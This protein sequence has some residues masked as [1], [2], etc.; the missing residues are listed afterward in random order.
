MIPLPLAGVLIVASGLLAARLLARRFGRLRRIVWCVKISDRRIEGYGY[1]RRKIAFDWLQV[2]RVELTEAGLTVVGP[3]SQCIDVP[4]LFPDFAELSHRIVGHAE[5][6]GVPI[7][8]DGRPWQSLDVYALF[9]FLA[10][11]SSSGTTSWR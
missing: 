5:F 4:H 11:D 9:P 3:D 2:H 1:N 7:F 6:Y 8:I 10:D